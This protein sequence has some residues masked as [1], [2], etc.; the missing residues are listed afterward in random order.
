MACHTP[1]LKKAKK[2]GECY[3]PSLANVDFSDGTGV[4]M[5]NGLFLCFFERWSRTGHH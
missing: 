2:Q 1:P 5:G 4:R 3:Y